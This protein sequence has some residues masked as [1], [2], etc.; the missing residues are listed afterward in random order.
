MRLPSKKK[1]MPRPLAPTIA[2]ETSERQSPLRRRPKRPPTLF[3]LVVLSV[4]MLSVIR[5]EPP[6]PSPPLTPAAMFVFDMPP[7]A[8]PATVS[9]I[10]FA[11]KEFPS[12]KNAAPLLFAPHSTAVFSSE[13]KLPGGGDERHSSPNKSS[14]QSARSTAVFRVLGDQNGIFRHG[15]KHGEGRGG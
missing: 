1:P 12:T 2:V 6:P 9:T 11:E 4:N 5:R 10:V 8:M 3:V 15:L 14:A 7:R 13:R